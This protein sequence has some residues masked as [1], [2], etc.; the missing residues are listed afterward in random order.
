MFVCDKNYS[1]CNHQ[2]WDRV[3]DVEQEAKECG[4]LIEV[5][6]VRHG[7]WIK[8]APYR[9]EDG[10][11]VYQFYCS[12]CGRYEDEKEPYCNC[13]CKMDLEDKNNE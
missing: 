3:E 9:D 7:R 13:G 1:C 2:Y 12:E 8:D 6:P 11:I 5:A 4:H 10:Y